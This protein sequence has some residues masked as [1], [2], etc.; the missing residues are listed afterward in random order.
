LKVFPEVELIDFDTAAQKALKFTH[1]DHIERVWDDGSI[2]SK[3]L[4][5][6]GCFIL[7]GVRQLAG[8]NGNIPYRARGLPDSTVEHHSNFFGEFWLEQH[9]EQNTLTQTLF[10]SPHGLPGFLY[11][12]LLYPF[13][14][15]KFHTQLRKTIKQSQQP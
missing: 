2:E 13:R 15:L 5:H 11:W 6:E 3:F 12:F 4:K 9:I 1:P 10:F 14:C 7:S 8:E